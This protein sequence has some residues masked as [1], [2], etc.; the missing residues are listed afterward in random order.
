MR[1]LTR[2]LAAMSVAVGLTAG[3]HSEAATPGRSVFGLNL[4][5]YGNAD[6][7]KDDP[8]TQRLLRSW[9][10]PFVRVPMRPSLSDAVLSDALRAVR[11][12]GAIP[13]V[14]LNGPGELPDDNAVLVRDLHDLELVR[15]V[16]R[17]HPVYLEYGNE[18]DLAHG[19][20]AQRYTTSWN[21]VISTI[22][23]GAPD[24]YKFVG[25]ANYQSDPGYVGTF[26]A[27]AH[28]RPDFVSWHEYVCTAANTSTCTSHL[29]NWTKHA[30]A[31]NAAEQS[32][33]GGTLPFLIT[34]WNA[35]PA[36]SPA[37]EALYADPAFIQPWTGAAI[38]ELR[39]LIPLGLAGAMIYTASDHDDFALVTPG[40]TPTPQGETFERVRRGK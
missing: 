35:D 32:A 21:A 39:S 6:Q 27:G 17:D 25:P 28:P 37:D 13:V 4:S 15:Q 2:L 29:A 10:V 19:V 8:G 31:V 16:F 9:H 20:T 18:D 36:N 40:P 12:I 1:N 30:T 38:G 23:T 24:R 34:E 5:L 7:V 11:N 22:K 33:I 14:I 26:V 3:P